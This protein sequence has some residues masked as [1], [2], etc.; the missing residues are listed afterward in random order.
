M[1]KILPRH[2][3]VR[4]TTMSLVSR[5]IRGHSPF[6]HRRFATDDRHRLPNVSEFRDRSAPASRRTKLVRRVLRR[7][8]PRV[9]LGGS[10]GRP[11]RHR[12][13]R[14]DVYSLGELVEIPA[15]IPRSTSI[16][17]SPNYNAPLVSRERLVVTVHDACH[18]ALPELMESR[19]KQEYAKLMLANV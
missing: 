6:L 7:L 11:P 4:L 5:G 12:P 13:A 2:G 19:L 16:L 14:S 17:W 9:D 15:R 1:G 18:I 8:P 3:V 10:C